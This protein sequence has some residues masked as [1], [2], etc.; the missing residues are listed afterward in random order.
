MSRQR[1]SQITTFAGAKRDRVGGRGL[2]EKVQRMI[3][4][5]PALAAKGLTKSEAAR[6]LGTKPDNFIAVVN[7]H[8]PDLEWR[9]GRKALSPRSLRIIDEAPALAANGFSQTDAARRLGVPT[10]GF[11]TTLARLLPDLE[12]CDGRRRN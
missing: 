1:I 12:W 7:R 2:T 3:D 4:E 8:L 9:D 6:R 5:A 10:N 11:A